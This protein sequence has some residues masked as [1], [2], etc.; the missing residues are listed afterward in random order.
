MKYFIAYKQNESDYIF[1]SSISNNIGKAMTYYNA[2][3]FL[4]KEN[5]KNV[6]KFLNEM[7]EENEYIV[8]KYEYSLTE[9]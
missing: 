1:V 6:C 2:L 8:L 4:S 5:A 7:D 3:D 9:E